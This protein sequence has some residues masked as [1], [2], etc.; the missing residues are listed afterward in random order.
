MQKAIL[1]AIL[2]HKSILVMKTILA[3]QLIHLAVKAAENLV[4][5]MH[6][7]GHLIS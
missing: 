3:I 6:S 2:S 5:I 7:I 4:S 1:I